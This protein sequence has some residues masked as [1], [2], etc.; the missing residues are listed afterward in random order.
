MADSRRQQ[1]VDAVKTRFQAIT[2]AGGYETNIGNNVFEWRDIPS[3]MVEENDMP[4]VL[5]RDPRTEIT[6]RVSKVQDHDLTIEAAVVTATA[7]IPVQVRKM[8]ADIYKAIGV[9]RT[10]GGKALD[11]LPVKDEMGVEHAGK[12][13]GGATVTFTIRHRTLSYDPY[14]TQ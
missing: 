3:V 10:W 13:F 14:N 4:C 6:Q 7:T 5:V 9:D 2:V 8:I 11:T 12:R 1:I